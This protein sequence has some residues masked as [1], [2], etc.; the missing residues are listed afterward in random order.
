M[1]DL[2]FYIAMIT[3]KIIFFIL[4]LFNRGGSAAP[5]L[6]SLKIDPDF[7]S[8]MAAQLK[9]SIVVS[10]TNGKTTTSRM[11]SA[12]ISASGEKV[13]HNRTGSNLPRGIVS[14]YINN[15]SLKSLSSDYIGIWEVDEG[16]LPQVA[17][18]L[19]PEY[20]VLT[21]LFRDQLDRY[22]ELDTIANKWKMTFKKLSAQSNIILNSDDPRIAALGK[23]LTAKTIYY[24][25]RT[26]KYGEKELPHATDT[27]YCPFC[28][29]K[30]TYQLSYVSHLGEYQCKNCGRIQP[31]PKVKCTKLEKINNQWKLTINTPEEIKLTVSSPGLYN[32]YNIL[33]AVSTAF[34][35]GF[36]IETIKNGLK[37]FIMPFGRFESIKVDNKTIK[38]VLTKNPTALN[39]ALKTSL[40][41]Y[42]EEKIAIY[43]L[44]NDLIADGKDTSWIWDANFKYLKQFNNLEK[45]MCSGIRAEDLALRIKYTEFNYSNKRLSLIKPIEKAVK[46]VK[47]LEAETI[48]IYPTYTA[49]LELRKFF[50]DKKYIH[51][52]WQD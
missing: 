36:E 50:E 3:G 10:G 11:I 4:R 20:I 34:K 25:L 17:R 27:N 24:G 26:K 33:A 19:K 48:L 40:Q 32:I 47:K 9:F 8:K 49:M 12:I 14:Q 22:G 30:L 16:L 21:N 39:Q 46:S 18:D 5:G 44:L 29:N 38:I 37:N 7:L 45:I 42:K 1:V 15:L 51:K 35:A 28:N 41:L 6:I 23:K 13:I 52:R 2:R 43:F 31:E